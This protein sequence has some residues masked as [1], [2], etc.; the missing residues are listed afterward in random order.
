MAT[1]SSSGVDISKVKGIHGAIN[2]AIF[3]SLPNYVL[4]IKGH[5]AGLFKSGNQTL[6]IHCDG[7]GSKLLTAD[8]VGKF[9]TVGIDCV[10]MNVNDIICLGARPLVLVDY[11]ALAKEDAWLVSEVLKGLQEGAK[12]AGCAIVGGETAILPDMITGG[13]RPFDLAATCVGVV[14]GEPITGAA[15]KPG[16]ILIGLESSGIHSNGYTLARQ[17]LSAKNWG[18]QMLAPTRIYVKPV[19][20]MIAACEIHG[21]AHITGGAFSK[22]SRIGGYG[23]VG[24]VLDNMPKMEGVMAE[25]EKKVASDYEMHRTFNCG[26]GMCIACPS[27]EEG[28]VIGIAKKHGIAAQRIGVVTPGSDVVLKKGKILLSLL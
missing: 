11:L 24:F 7:V 2:D 22:L 8:A 27:S 19:L 20:E 6:A 4:P 23:H 10:A 5:Y 3:S 14:E 9:D 16:D 17:L 18:K 26:I 21:I 12:Q 1:Y 13:K 28:K 15:M 25:L